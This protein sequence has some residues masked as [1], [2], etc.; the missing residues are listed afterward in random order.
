MFD[1]LPPG[2]FCWRRLTEWRSA[3]LAWWGRCQTITSTTS[4]R[5]IERFPLHGGWTEQRWKLHLHALRRWQGGT[6]IYIIARM[7]QQRRP[8]GHG[9]IPPILKILIKQ[10]LLGFL[11]GRLIFADFRSV[12]QLVCKSYDFFGVWDDALHIYFWPGQRSLS[13]HADIVCLFCCRCAPESLKT[14]TFS[15]ATDTWMFGVTLWEMFTH[16]QEPWLG[17]N[18][19]QVNAHVHAQKE[20]RK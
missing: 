1:T 10:G 18:G 17:L 5:S 16:G 7:F 14:R 20:K 2:T 12:E 13:V 8:I 19:S 6:S 4:C 11:T 3:T 15:H 9:W